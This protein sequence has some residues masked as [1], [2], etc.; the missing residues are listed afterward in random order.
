MDAA[1]EATDTDAPG[2]GESSAGD[3]GVSEPV[4]EERLFAAPSGS[5]AIGPGNVLAGCDL[6]QRLPQP[7]HLVSEISG[8]ES[9][10]VAICFPL[11]LQRL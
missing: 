1:S 4:P 9:Y 8:S 6:F 10:R 5:G 11:C 3:F 7:C 2:G